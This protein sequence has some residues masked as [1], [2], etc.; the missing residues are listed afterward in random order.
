MSKENKDGILIFWFR[1]DLRLHDNTGLQKALDEG[2][3]VLPIFIFDREILGKLENKKD[4][5]VDYIRQALDAMNRELKKKNTSMRVFHGKPFEIFKK[6]DREYRIRGVYCNRDYEPYAIARDKEIYNW[7]KKKDIPLR[8]FKDQVIFDKDEIL[9]QS[10]SPYKVY[11]PYSKAWRDKLDAKAYT[12]VKMNFKNILELPYH[13]VPELKDI[14]FEKTDMKFETPHLDASVID[15]YDKTRDFPAKNGTTRLGIALRFGTISIRKCVQYALEHNDTWLS[16]LIWREFFMQI[17]YHYPR[18]VDHAFKEKY[19]RIKWRNN[20]KEFEKWCKGETGFPFVDAGMRQLNETGYMH[21]RVR[22]IVASFLVKDLLIDWRWGEAYFAEK[23]NDFELAS[24]N[25]NWQ[26]AAGCGC[27]AAP[28][29]RIF[30]PATQI[31]KYDKNRKY[32]EKWVPEFE[33]DAYT[34][35]IVNHKEARERTLDAYKKA[36]DKD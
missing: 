4:R 7:F 21:N 12:S 30:N 34:K 14:G 18:V 25:G 1:R 22:M 27:D 19:D 10:N 32:I 24:N 6:L 15:T 26:W 11:T 17:L 16:E 35:P 13:A 20:E 5:R 23:L 33:K 29:F 9:T 28:Y 8:A 36:V 2:K 3:P 31:D